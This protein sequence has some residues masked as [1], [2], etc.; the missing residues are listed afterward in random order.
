MA[1]V[2]NE[3]ECVCRESVQMKNGVF[4]THSLTMSFT[5]TRSL[6]ASG[7]ARC[8]ISIVLSISSLIETKIDR[9]QREEGKKGYLNSMAR[10]IRADVCHD[11]RRNP[12]KRSSSMCIT[13][14]S[15]GGIRWG[16]RAHA[17]NRFNATRARDENSMIGSRVLLCFLC[18]RSMINR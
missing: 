8:F 17:C 12:E 14:C 2:E 15:L 6:P 7:E 13:M 5:R 9:R 1:E 10:R 4:A 18:C 16:E 11:S 3:N